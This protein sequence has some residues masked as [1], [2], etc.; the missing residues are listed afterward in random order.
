MSRLRIDWWAVAIAVTGA[1]VL[2]PEIVA[3]TP[4][5]EQ[6]D[7]VVV[8]FDMSHRGGWR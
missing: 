2:A 3:V 7:Q 1:V 4:V 5:G 6:R 8:W